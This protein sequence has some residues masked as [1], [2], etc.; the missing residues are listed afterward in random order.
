MYGHL[1][2]VIVHEKGFIVLWKRLY[3]LLNYKLV[4]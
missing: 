2:Y 4:T 3:D 1:T